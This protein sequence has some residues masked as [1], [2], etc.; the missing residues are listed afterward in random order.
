M[1][2][3][4]LYPRF[5]GY[6]VDRER[7]LEVIDSWDD[8]SYIET[9]KKVYASA[10]DGVLA[11]Y[12]FAAETRKERLEKIIA[13]RE[14][15]DE[16][17]RDMMPRL[18][19]MKAAMMHLGARTKWY[20][21]DNI[22]EEQAR[23]AMRYCREMRPQY[24]MLQMMQDTAYPIQDFENEWIKEDMEMDAIVEEVMVEEIPEVPAVE[25][26]AAAEPAAEE[27]PAPEAPVVPKK[28]GRKPGSKNKKPSA[29]AKKAPEAPAVPKKRGRKSNAEKAAMATAK[30]AE[31][32]VEAPKKKKKDLPYYLL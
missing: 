1:T 21:L 10:A 16:E 6:E 12:D 29:A 24:T 8:A 28:R 31:P 15:I 17:I 27:A 26:A 23:Q 5:I 3:A 11:D 25:E 9:L 22:G 32:V 18:E 19:K 14:A 4:D 13:N 2:M 30:A 7:A 20:Q